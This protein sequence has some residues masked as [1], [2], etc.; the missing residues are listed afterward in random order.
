MTFLSESKNEYERTEEEPESLGYGSKLL[1]HLSETSFSYLETRI[2]IIELHLQ[3][4]YFPIILE[5]HLFK[6][7]VSSNYYGGLVRKGREG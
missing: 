3:S 6:R 7:L 5:L 2:M 1:C 4:S